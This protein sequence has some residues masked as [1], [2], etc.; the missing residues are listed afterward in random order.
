[1]DH[2]T[3]AIVEVTAVTLEDAFLK[4]GESTVAIMLDIET[5]EEKDTR[6][7]S[8]SGKDLRYLLFNW[9]EEIVFQ[10]I[11]E[12]FAPKRFDVKITKGTEY[13]IDAILYGESLDLKKHQ[14]RVEIKAPTFH[15]MIIKKEDNVITMKY[16]LDL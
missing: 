11:T 12:G 4:A 7:I 9:L 13:R 5:I 1:L 2:T 16:L 6:K 8:V 3:D 14:F 10:V 15:Q